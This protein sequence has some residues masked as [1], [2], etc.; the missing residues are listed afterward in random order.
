MQ[1]YISVLDNIT[2]SIVRY[3]AC[4]RPMLRGVKAR[5][6]ELVDASNMGLTRW[7]E[8]RTRTSRLPFATFSKAKAYRFDRTPNA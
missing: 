2:E 8:E 7:L 6:D 3:L 1:G 5:K 4:A